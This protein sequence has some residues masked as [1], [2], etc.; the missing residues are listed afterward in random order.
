M[1][2]LYSLWKAVEL[3]VCPDPDGYAK[4]I[5]EAEVR[6]Q[7]SYYGRDILQKTSVGPRRTLRLARF[8]VAELG[9]PKGSRY[10]AIC[11][12]A[13]ARGLRLCPAEVGL[14]L[15]LQYVDQPLGEW[16]VIAMEPITDEDGDSDLFSLDRGGDALWLLAAWRHPG[17]FWSPDDTFVFVLGE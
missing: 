17:S 4:A 11:E 5:V 14:A 7:M 6:M 13:N 9:F 2:D 15:R 16:L 10:D 1:T 3:G 12:R 8:T